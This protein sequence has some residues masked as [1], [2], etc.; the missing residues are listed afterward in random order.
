MLG[1]AY[2]K[3]SIKKERERLRGEG[4]EIKIIGLDLKENKLWYPEMEEKGSMFHDG[5]FIERIVG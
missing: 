1:N 4:D 5:K 2:N 3:A